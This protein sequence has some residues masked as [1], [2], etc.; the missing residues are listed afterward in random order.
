MM[1]M[2]LFD[3]WD[4]TPL[5]QSLDGEHLLHV[6]SAACAANASKQSIRQAGRSYGRA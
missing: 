4:A 2:S 5:L 1:D 6:R 3:A